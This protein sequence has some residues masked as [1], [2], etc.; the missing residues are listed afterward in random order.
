VFALDFE[1]GRCVAEGI[2]MH[3]AADGHGFDFQFMPR[4]A[5]AR[6]GARRE[7]CE[8]VGDRHGA[9]VS[10]PGSVDDLIFHRFVQ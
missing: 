2:D 3:S 9:F 10:I 1:I 8:V 6:Q 5:L 4:A 7:A